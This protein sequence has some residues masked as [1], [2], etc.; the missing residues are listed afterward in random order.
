MEILIILI[1]MGLVI[2]W[3]YKKYKKYS[4][5]KTVDLKPQV[6]EPKITVSIHTR[7]STS[8]ENPD[9][10]YITPTQDGGWVLNPKSTF[11]LTI[12]GANQTIAS[13][14]KGLLDAGYSLGSYAHARTIIPIIARFNLRCKEI[15]DYVKK[16]KPLYFN[17]IEELKK[18]SAEWASASNRDKEDLLI[19]FR[20]QAIESL[21]VRP[22]CDLET[23]FECEPADVTIDDAVIDQFGYENLLLYLRYA[24]NLDKVRVI[25]ADHY[26]RS[27]FEKLV[28]LGLA[29]KGTDISLH[30]IL[31]TLKLKDM[32]DLVVDLNQKPF[33]RKAKAI[34]FL[35]NLSDIKERIGKVVTFRELFQLKPLPDE[36]SN[37]DLNR[38][39]SAWRYTNEIATIIAHTYV[40]GGYSSR[41]MHQEDVVPS[42]IKGWEIL[43]VGDDA[44]CPYCKHAATKKYP[45][46]QRPK[47]PLHIGCRCTVL[48]K[49]D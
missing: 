38:I 15:E 30:A 3:M 9:T 10:G 45:K 25:P 12:Y 22:Y 42:F 17:K 49:I 31:E 39:S 21:D 36:F 16:F 47:V 2:I 34:E 44:T 11:P 24:N 27:G 33:G 14:L 48:S 5:Q 43:P 26:E 37:I 8:F 1:I 20:Q 19:G 4:T 28:E 23:L 41:D 7:P 18:S 13:E 32:N 46:K 29:R 35:M 40:M 6:S